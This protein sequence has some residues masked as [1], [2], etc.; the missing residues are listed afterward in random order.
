LKARFQGECSW[1]AETVAAINGEIARLWEAAWINGKGSKNIK[2]KD[3]LTQGELDQ[4]YKE[5][6]KKEKGFCES[7]NL[8]NIASAMRWKQ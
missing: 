6:N 4:L 3:C 1:I 7:M 5:I 8:G 2:T